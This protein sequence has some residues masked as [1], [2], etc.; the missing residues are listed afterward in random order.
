M[1]DRN[2]LSSICQLLMKSGLILDTDLNV[3][4]CNAMPM[5]KLGRYGV[6][7]FDAQSLCDFWNSKEISEFY[8]R[9][10]AVPSEKCVECDMYPRCGG[11]CISQWFN[12]S[13]DELMNYKNGYDAIHK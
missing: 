6:D 5:V 1:E 10:R 13:I 9:I 3:L 12:Y 2:Q 8:N 4:P 11:G 7:F